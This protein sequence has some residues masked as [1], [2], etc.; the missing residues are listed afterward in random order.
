MSA[1]FAWAPPLPFVNEFLSLVTFGVENLDDCCED[2]LKL[3]MLAAA[4]VCVSYAAAALGARVGLDDAVTRWIGRASAVAA[5]CVAYPVADQLSDGFAWHAQGLQE[6]L[7]AK[8]GLPAS[9]P[10][11]TDRVPAP[12]HNNLMLKVNSSTNTRVALKE[13]LSSHF[14]FA[15]S[16]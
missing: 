7:R 8:L 5:V 10:D 13:G 9:E 1:L 15:A 16:R 12:S 4:Y 3:G 11:P 2:V 6:S 14:R